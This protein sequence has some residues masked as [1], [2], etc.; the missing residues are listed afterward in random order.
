MKT[1]FTYEDVARLLGLGDQFL[2]DWEENEGADPSS[3][4]YAECKARRQEWDAIRPLL[5][6]APGLLKT[7]QDELT[8]LDAEARTWAGFPATDPAYIELEN[9]RDKI[10]A[11]IAKAGAA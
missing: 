6:A 2:D 10:R 4:C 3:D 11:V 7:L 9:R 8:V 1:H 5:L